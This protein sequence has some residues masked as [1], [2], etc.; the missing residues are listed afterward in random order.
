MKID[1]DLVKNKKFPSSVKSSILKHSQEYRVL[2][3]LRYLHPDKFDTMITDESPDLQDSISNIGI[4]VTVAVDFRD[5]RA[6]REFANLKQ[7]NGN[8]EKHK[9]AIV[10]SGYSILPM[11]I[12]DDIVAIS[13]SGTSD[14]E[15]FFFQESI[16]RKTEKLESYRANFKKMGLAILLPEIPTFYAENHFSEWIS[17]VYDESPNLF[18]FVYVISHRFCLYYDTQANVVTKYLLTQEESRSLA[19]I[20]RM[21]AEGEL[22]LENDEWL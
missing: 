17:E 3:T 5:M 11:P 20:G 21:T 9:K 22:S 10:S 6:S 13:T 12:K 19:T 4:E 1:T 8:P 15:K 18:D 14:G 7:K 16:R 2:A